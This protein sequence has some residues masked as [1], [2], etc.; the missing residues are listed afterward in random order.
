MNGSEKQIKWAIEL[1][2]WFNENIAP[3]T[4]KEV[5]SISEYPE[6]VNYPF[7][8]KMVNEILK[9]QNAS[10]WIENFQ[11]PGAE[12]IDELVMLCEDPDQEDW[13]DFKRIYRLK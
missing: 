9:C 5:Q 7:F 2:Q 12:H 4:E 1:K 8:R 10:M 11:Y 13:E 3:M 6:D